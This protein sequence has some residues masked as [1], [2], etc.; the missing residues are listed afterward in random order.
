M[1][2]Y[3]THRRRN[4]AENVNRLSK[5]QYFYAGGYRSHPLISG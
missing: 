2:G 5:V 3:G 4:I 1:D